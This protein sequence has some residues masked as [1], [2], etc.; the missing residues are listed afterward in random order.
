MLSKLTLALAIALSLSACSTMTG[1]DLYQYNA[2][3]E[4]E[5]SLADGSSIRPE[6]PVSTG[7]ETTGDVAV[8][9]DF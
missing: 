6:Q 9:E 3:G 2:D 5:P 7:T 4:S 8:D 1:P